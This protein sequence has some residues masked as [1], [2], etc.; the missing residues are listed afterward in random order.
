M[1]IPP[2]PSVPLPLDD[3]KGELF[4]KAIDRHDYKYLCLI[5]Q[6]RKPEDIQSIFLELKDQICP[7]MFDRFGTSVIIDLCL[8]CD[9]QQ[10]NQLVSSLT[11][12]THLLMLLCLSS[13]GHI[14]GHALSSRVSPDIKTKV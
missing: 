6:H 14:S 8:V 9:E 2:L 5:L 3:W 1:P 4:W 13:K 7:L 10:M 12:D 11:A